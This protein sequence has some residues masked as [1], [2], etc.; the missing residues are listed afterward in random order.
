MSTIPLEIPLNMRPLLAIA[1][2]PMFLLVACGGRHEPPGAAESMSA[3]AALAGSAERRKEKAAAPPLERRY[4]AVRHAL[5]IQTE[6]EG[7]ET[8]WRA[9]NEACEAA[10]C[11]ILSSSLERDA[12]RRPAQAELEARLPPHQVDGFLK[13]VSALGSVGTHSR[14]AEDKTDEVIDTEAKLKNMAE[15]RDNLRRLMATPQARLQDLIEVERELARVQG[16]LD[17]LAS[18]RKALS[19]Q[20]DKVH[21]KLTFTA[22]P[23]ALEAGVWTPVGEA[24]TG[25]GRVLAHSAAALIT[26]VAAALPWALLLAVAGAIVRA[27]WRRRRNCRPAVALPSA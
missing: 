19:S 21:V 14:T 17:S 24:T 13:Q 7:V 6:A 4:L 9:A 27:L 5:R 12:Q 16:E 11:E 26:F 15:F 23:S 8:A 20:T 10:G 18:R 2:V 1:F 25:A 22:R 3:P